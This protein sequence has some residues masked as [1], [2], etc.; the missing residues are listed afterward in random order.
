MGLFDRIKR[1]FT[2]EDEVIKHEETKESI[3]IEKYEKGMEK[4]RR[5]FSDRL[6]E[7][8]ADFREIDEDF[9]EDFEE[10]HIFNKAVLCI[11]QD[12]LD[13]GIAKLPK[14]FFERFNCMKS[15]TFLLEVVPKHVSKGN[16]LKMLGEI[17]GISLDEMAACGDEE[18]DLPMLTVVGYPIAMGNGSKEVK[19]VAKYVTATNEESGVA[20]AIYHILEMN[21]QA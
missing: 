14:E 9:F 11:E 16:G 20:Q 6:N 19:E 4:T 5:S 3:V 10:G 15:R 7:F 8:L 18:N 12:I 2:G 17:L 21:K 1:A 13:E